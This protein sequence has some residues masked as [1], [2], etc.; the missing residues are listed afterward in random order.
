MAEFM[1]ITL[2]TATLREYSGEVIVPSRSVPVC[3]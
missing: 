3:G 2:Y 1:S